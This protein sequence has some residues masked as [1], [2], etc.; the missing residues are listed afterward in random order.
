MIKAARV[1]VRSTWDKPD[2]AHDDD[3]DDDDGDDGD[4]DNSGCE[5]SGEVNLGQARSSWSR[6]GFSLG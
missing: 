5:G 6:T 2:L 1:V 4:D 3:D